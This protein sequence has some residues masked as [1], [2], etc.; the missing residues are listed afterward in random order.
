MKGTTLQFS[1]IKIE[2]HQ[3]SKVT[4]IG[5]SKYLIATCSPVEDEAENSMIV[6]YVC[7]GNLMFVKCCNKSN[8]NKSDTAMNDFL[9]DKSI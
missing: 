1:I 5:N 9:F 8:N 7:S 6:R 2:N 4:R 3:G